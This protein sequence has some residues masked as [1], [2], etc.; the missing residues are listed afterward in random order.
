[1]KRRVIIGKDNKFPRLLLTLLIALTLLFAVAPSVLIYA[2]SGTYDKTYHVAAWGDDITGDGTESN[3]YATLAKTA[4]EINMAGTG[5]RYLV[6]VMTD[7]DSTA[8]AR[9][10]NNSVTIASWGDAPVIVTRAAGFAPLSDTARGWYNPAMLEIGTTDFTPTAPQLSL[11]LENIIFDDAYRHE[12]TT[13]RY[14]P[15]PSVG[16]GMAY[17]QDAMVAAYASSTTIIVGE[18]AE[19]R[20][21][22]GMSAIRAIDFA[23]VVLKSGSLIADINPNA[24]TTRAGSVI[25][26]ENGD[27]AI[28]LVNAKLDMQAGSAITGIANAHGIK[29]GGTVTF[30]MNGTISGLIGARGRDT[31]GD[32]RGVKSA[33]IFQDGTTTLD[34]NTGA[35]GAALIGPEGQVINNQSK[36]GAV[37]VRGSGARLA[38]YGKI[39]SNTNLAGGT[40]NLQGTNGAGVFIINS[41]VVDL[42]D[43][44]E[45]CNNRI[46]GLTGYGGA[47]SVQQHGSRLIMN[48]GF[49]SGNTA[50]SGGVATPLD[51]APGVAVN[52]GD[53]RFEMNGGIIN[54][55][56]HAVHLFNNSG[57]NSNGCVVLSAGRVSGVTVHT[58]TSPG[59]AVQRHLNIAESVLIDSGYASVAGR[60][61]TPISADFSIG[62]PNQA[63]YAS[64]R[65]ALPQDWTMPTTDGN[66]IG[67][68]AQK[69][70]T[71]TFSVPVPTAGTAPT[72]YDRSLGIYFVAVQATQADGTVLA[73]NPVRFYPTAIDNGQIILT[74]PLGTYE[75]G[76]TVAVIQPARAYGEIE[77]TG[78]ATLE[79]HLGSADYLIP[80]TANYSMPS[81]LLSQLILDG[82]TAANTTVTLTV[83]PYADLIINASSLT[84]N[85]E[86]FELEGAAFWDFGAGE[87]IVPLKLKTGW[88]ST[89]DL[90]TCFAFDGIMAAA[91][92][93][94][95]DF[96]HLTGWISITGS[97]ATPPPLYL[98]YG[99]LV[100]TEM[101]KINDPDPGDDDS[102]NPDPNDTDDD[103]DDATDEDTD[104]SGPFEGEDGQ[105]L[106]GE[107]GENSRTNTPPTGDTALLLLCALSACLV[108]SG[109]CVVAQQRGKKPQRNRI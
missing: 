83:R 62:N 93:R 85:S 35:P 25:N 108:L 67:F 102:G 109:L 48:G 53:A 21:F 22:G 65:A 90:N 86:L 96:L 20:N 79:H 57:D 5:K 84:L 105:E 56:L 66:V 107:G 68:W 100:D 26:S 87:L 23:S 28:I 44:S 33:I 47:V 92:F 10:Y 104:D 75:N 38:V 15:T 50:P 78:P 69:D 60:R 81:G 94:D 71:E 42:E 58:T 7:L 9:Y 55:G 52:K 43:G 54:N 11:T 6:L 101:V 29:T 27:A 77:F 14:A 39:N 12:G 32:G 24:A 61:V 51:G 19:L 1:M 103:T 13:F 2:D 95:G 63:N 106:E 36:S 99:N 31:A 89:I 91:D 70:G 98:I 80:Y 41:A 40:L 4:D 30:S 59:N 16:T 8:C 18:G 37:H 82:H 72:N 76:A 49:I 88:A 34:P 64:I 45:V 46:N 3:P 73:S 17:A 97:T 74:L